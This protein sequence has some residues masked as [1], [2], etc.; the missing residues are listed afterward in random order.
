VTEYTVAQGDTL[1][2]IATK[3]RVKLKALEDANPGVEPTKLK[4][5]QKLHIPPPA[6]ITAAASTAP[7]TDSVNGE[8]S[9][10]VKSGDTLL[11]IA[12]EFKVS[13]KSIRSANN[14]KTDKIVVGQ[15][16]KIPAKT[17]ASPTPASDPAITTASTTT[18]SNTTGTPVH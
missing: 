15:D 13:V 5:G 7:G 1:G 3:N 8:Q 2:A 9:Y 11:K 12:G 16:L 10:K 18:A 14:L 4:I 17:T 6:A